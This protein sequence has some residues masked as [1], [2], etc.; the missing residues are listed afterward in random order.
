ML[1]VNA[2][3]VFLVARRVSLSMG[4]LRK[5]SYLLTSCIRLVGAMSLLLLLARIQ[6]IGG[7]LYLM[8]IVDAG[9]S[10]EHRAYLPDKLD[11]TILAVFE[12]FCAKLEALTGRKTC[13][14]QTDG[15]FDTAAWR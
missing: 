8:I 4:K 5:I 7:K 9:T 14:L 12:V 10:F 13:H 1:A 15:A 2:K 11:S 6:S 3:T